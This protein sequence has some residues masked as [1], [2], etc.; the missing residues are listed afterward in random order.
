MTSGR[1]AIHWVFT[2]PGI[3]SAS[4]NIKIWN[5]FIKIKN[6]RSYRFVIFIANYRCFRRLKISR[7]GRDHRT[8]PED[9]RQ[10]YKIHTSI[11]ERYWKIIGVIMLS[12]LSKYWR[13]ATVRKFANSTFPVVIYNRLSL[14]RSLGDSEI[15]RDIRTSTYQIYRT[16]EKNKSNNH[17]SQMIR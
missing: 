6:D 1:I 3:R 11:N 4:I 13:E 2:I 16:E 9:I 10:I 17:I 8:V 12:S 7:N 15:L 14:F 5:K